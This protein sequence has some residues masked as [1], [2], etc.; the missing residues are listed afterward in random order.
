MDTGKRKTE[1]RSLARNLRAEISDEDWKKKSGSITDRFLKSDLYQSAENIHSYVS[2]NQRRE[3]DTFGIIEHI[4]LS[5][6]TVS[7]PISNFKDLSMRHIEISSLDDFK[8]NEWG[9]REPSRSDI[10][11]EPEFFDLIIVPL[12]AAD[13]KGNR[14]GYGKGFYDR[15]LKQT[16]AITVGLVFKSFIFNEIPV[17]ENDQKLDYLLTEKSL[18]RVKH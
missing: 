12:L 11:H 1:L 15:F 10:E 5:D 8:V 2:M 16:R 9:I 6:K 14:L 13:I 3:V 17:D 18:V 4:L 7:V